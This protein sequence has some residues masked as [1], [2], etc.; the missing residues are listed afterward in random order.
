MLSAVIWC[1][2]TGVLWTGVGIFFHLINSKKIDIM[3]LMLSCSAVL[4][5]LCMGTVRWSRLAADG[6]VANQTLPLVLVMSLAGAVMMGGMLLM[7]ASMRCERADAAWSICQSSLVIPFSLGVL[8]NHEET[9]LVNLL[10]IALVIAGISIYGRSK[11]TS[12]KETGGSRTWFLAALAGFAVI[13]AGQ[14]LFS[15]PSYWEGWTDLYSL[16]IPIQAL[17]GLLMLAA[18]KPGLW[19]S[20]SRTVWLYGGFFAL[21][22]YAGR[23]ALY[24]SLDSLSLIS[25]RSI[26]YPV[27]LGLSILGFVIY[28]AIISGKLRMSALAVSACL[29]VGLVMLGLRA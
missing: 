3:A 5:V 12:G 19:L 9:N 22:T 10:G 16:R 25:M 8:I 23:W 6:W 2:V 1:L 26:A 27:C 7:V 17:A 20:M 4:A 14:Y 21:L 11:G 18:V 24:Q 15:I 28:H 29:M 13:G